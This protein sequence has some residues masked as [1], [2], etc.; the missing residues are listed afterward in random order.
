[1][2]KAGDKDMDK[3]SKNLAQVL[4]FYPQSTTRPK[5]LTNQVFFILGLD[6]AFKQLRYLFTQP[7]SRFYNLLIATLCPL[8]T[9]PI[10]NTKLIKE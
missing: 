10:T 7:Q 2:L 3:L 8:F 6:T 9:G 4:G 5:Y 1:M